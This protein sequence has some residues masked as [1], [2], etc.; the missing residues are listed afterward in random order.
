VAR[1]H[2]AT[3]TKGQPN[4]LTTGRPATGGEEEV[5]SEPAGQG[6]RERGDSNPIGH[7]LVDLPF[8]LI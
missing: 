7:V 3:P 4:P 5:E 6:V 2:L 8:C 1:L